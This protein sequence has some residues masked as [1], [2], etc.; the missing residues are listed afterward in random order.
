MITAAN[1]LAESGYIVDYS[2]DIKKYNLDK[3]ILRQE[4]IGI[5]TKINGLIQ[6]GDSG[7]VCQNRFSDVSQKDGWVCYVAETAADR[8]VVNGQNPTFRPK[9]NMTRYEAMV[10]ALK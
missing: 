7:Y 2:T 1:S 3:P 10:L 5:I 4:S 6:E 8:G 9:D